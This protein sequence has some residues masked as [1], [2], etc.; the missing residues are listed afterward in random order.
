M[1]KLTTQIIDSSR[2]KPAAGVALELYR[3]HEDR[4]E[5][6]IRGLTGKD[7]RN[8]SA[9]LSESGMQAGQ[10]ELDFHVGDYFATLGVSLSEPRF[11]DVISLRIGIADANSDLHVPLLVSPYGYSMVRGG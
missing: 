7:G 5:L 11:L 3:L 6:L 9:L 2:G 4:R 1:A 10:Y 8:H